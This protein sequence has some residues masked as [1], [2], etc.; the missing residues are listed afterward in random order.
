MNTLFLTQNDAMQIA[1]QHLDEKSVDVKSMI[2]DLGID[3]E[4]YEG[5]VSTCLYGPN[6]KDHTGRPLRIMIRTPRISTHDKGR[7]T[8]P[9]KG[10]VLALN[11]NF[12]RKSLA[13]VLPHAQFEDLGIKD[14][15]VVTV[16]ENLRPI[17]LE[18]VMRTYN[19]YTTTDTSLYVHHK[20][21]ERVFCGHKLRDDL[22]PNCVL[23][24]LID[25]PST[26]EGKDRSMSAKELIE[27]GICT[28]AQYD[29]MND[30]GRTSYRIVEAILEFKDIIL[31]DTK[32][33]FGVNHEGQILAMDE[34]YTMDSS[35]F[36]PVENWKKALGKE[37]TVLS[38]S[39]E[40]ARA[41]SKGNEPYTDEERALIS[42]RYMLGIQELTGEPFIPDPRPFE[43]KVREELEYILNTYLK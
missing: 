20:K 8:I 39:K 5:K 22:I 42:A 9:K 13:K 3:C 12:M 15:A 38:W 10:E 7:G 37:E 25:T 4:I 27:M 43:Q 31:A 17:M 35:R 14:N 41:F 34:L 28:E 19:A 23:P 24:N 1:M 18:F 6:I 40:F 36:W 2:S 32:I 16:S 33:E 29:V 11:H 30:M 21:G 26:K